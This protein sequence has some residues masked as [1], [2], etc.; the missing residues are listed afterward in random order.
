MSDKALN[1]TEYTSPGVAVFCGRD[2]GQA[3]RKDAGIRNGDHVAITVPDPCFALCTTFLFELIGGCTATV[4]NSAFHDGRVQ[5]ALADYARI[6]S[7]T[8]SIF[9]AMRAGQRQG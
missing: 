8:G 5:E 9:N 4:V 3:I 6:T 1:L 2:R 7:M